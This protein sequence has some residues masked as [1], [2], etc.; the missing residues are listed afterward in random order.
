M[1]FHKIGRIFGILAGF[2]GYASGSK[3]ISVQGFFSIA[4]I[5]VTALFLWAV[6]KACRNVRL[7]NDPPVMPVF[8]AASALFNIV[9]FVIIEMPV[10]PRYFIPFMVLYIPL[11]AML[12]QHTEKTYKYTKHAALVC[13]IALFIFGQ[14]CLNFHSLAAR[15]TNAIRTGYIQYLLDNGLHFGFATFENANVTTELTNGSIALA[16]LD[17]RAV[18]VF[19]GNRFRLTGYLRLVKYNDPLYHTGESFLLFTPS[20]WG[21]VRSGQ[22]PDWLKP[23]YEDSNFVII[24]YPSAEAI[25]RD[26]LDSGVY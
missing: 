3:L 22:S 8:F 21:L 15:N 13:G 9:V 10:V 24:R 26:F 16:G 4:A 1:I 14:G 23:D 11:A 20:E 6:V 18:S 7:Q 12:F 17:P 2:F 25:H 5:I 19:G